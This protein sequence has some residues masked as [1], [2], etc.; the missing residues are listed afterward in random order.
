MNT[1]AVYEYYLLWYMNALGWGDGEKPLPVYL[2]DSLTMK[3]VLF[4]YI[5]SKFVIYF[6]QSH[7]N[8]DCSN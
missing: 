5:I 1:V 2:T 7:P 8:T 6:K 4:T 3:N